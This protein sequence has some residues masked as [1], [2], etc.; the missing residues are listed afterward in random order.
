MTQQS[1][2]DNAH[3][4]NTPVR[5]LHITNRLGVGGPAMYVTLLAQ[6]FKARGYDVEVICGETDAAHGDMT[7]FADRYGIQPRIF[8]QLGGV[9]TPLNDIIALWRLYHFMREYQPDVVHTHTTKAGFVGR[10]AAYLARVPVIVHTFHSHV[11]EGYFGSALTRFF[12]LMERLA[13]RM[14][15]V[16]LTLTESLRSELA[17]EYHITRRGRI[18][19]LPLGLD[20]ASFADTPRKLGTFRAT[21]NI[22]ADAP[23]VGII[24]RLVPIKNHKLFLQSARRIIETNPQVRFVIIG[25]GEE[26]P[27]LESLVHDYHL[28]NAVTFTG[29]QSNL[30]EI[31]SDLDVSVVSSINEGTPV[32]VIESLSATCP[33]VATRVGG[34]PDLL[35][36]GAYG[37]LVPPNDPSAMARALLKVLNNPPDVTEAQTIMLESYGMERLVNDMDSLYRGLLAKKRR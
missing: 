10:L 17:D 37:V 2:T 16:V 5:I 34:V 8:P 6:G 25:D 13:A 22:P 27:M 32:S 9:V 7:Y 30:L 15:D 29:W 18:M 36:G 3:P 33:V 12:I 14:S 1:P 19:V 11:F 28:E 31:Y 21:W 23:L 20:L 26:R 35:N 24:G 4:T